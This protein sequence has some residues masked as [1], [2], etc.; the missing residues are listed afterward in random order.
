MLLFVLVTHLLQPP[1]HQLPTH[2]PT[3]KQLVWQA[4]ASMG[5]KLDSAQT[6]LKCIE[7]PVYGLTLDTRGIPKIPKSLVSTAFE[8]LQPCSSCNL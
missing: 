5:H 3:D 4:T 2:R 7:H 8:A 6:K 1:Q